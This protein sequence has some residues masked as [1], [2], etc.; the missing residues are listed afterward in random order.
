MKPKVAVLLSG[1]GV[2]DGAEIHESVCALLSLAQL[3]AEALCVAPNIPQHH[4]INHLTGEEMPEK[5]N[6][7]VE[8]A[9]IARGHIQPLDQV[10]VDEFDALMM[11]GGFGVAKNFTKWAFDGP[12]G[13]IHP[14]IKQFIQAFH[15]AGK[16][17]AAVCMS[18]TTVAK[19]LEGTGAQL[20]LTIGSTQA[21]SPYDI[22]AIQEGLKQVGAQ[23]ID[24]NIEEIL[25]DETNRLITCPCYMMEGSII[26]IYNGIRRATEALMAM[27][28]VRAEL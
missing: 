4:V 22:K 27:L 16:P 15:K 11:P 23:A 25:I 17:I 2:Y 5:R 24:Q 14:A 9:R 6:V 13:E 7:L 12:N 26:D 28:K 20:R 18:P 10:K 1:C 3:G 19:A 21:P 8:A